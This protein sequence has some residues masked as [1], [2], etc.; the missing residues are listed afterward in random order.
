MLAKDRIRYFEMYYCGENIFNAACAF[1][2][3]SLM[4]LV[5]FGANLSSIIGVVVFC[6]LVIKLMSSLLC[7]QS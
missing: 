4:A 1:L 5:A 7:R 3:K 6:P 2:G